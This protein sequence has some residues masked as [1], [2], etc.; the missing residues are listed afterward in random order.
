M[1]W[2]CMPAPHK[3]RPA[4]QMG[5]LSALASRE[6]LLQALFCLG[7]EPGLRCPFWLSY[8][9]FPARQVLQFTEREGRRA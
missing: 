3:R 2:G 8:F 1:S 7:G 9:R 4:L 5:R 6:P